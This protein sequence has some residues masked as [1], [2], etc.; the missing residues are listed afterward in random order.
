MPSSLLRLSVAVLLLMLVGC[1]GDDGTESSGTTVTTT[2]T[3]TTDE[4]TTTT[5]EPPTTTTEA[6]ITVGSTVDGDFATVTLH[7]F[8]FPIA[9]N[10]SAEGISTAG[11]SF[12]VADVEVCA[13]TGPVSV[14]ELDFTVQTTDSRRWEAFNTQVGAR[15]PRFSADNLPTDLCSRGWISFEVGDG[16]TAQAL[17]LEGGNSWNGANP[18]TEDTVVWQLA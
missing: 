1:G 14:L 11:T 18:A 9:G 3:T 17:V 2:A 8:E 10:E 13:T 12:A 16:S 15:D 5:T 4:A 7:A 6:P